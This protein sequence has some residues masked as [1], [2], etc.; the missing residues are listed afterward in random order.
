MSTFLQ[1]EIYDVGGTKRDVSNQFVRTD[2][3]DL[4]NQ[5]RLSVPGNLVELQGGDADYVNATPGVHGFPE[6]NGEWSHINAMG[7]GVVC[8]RQLVVSDSSI[9]EGVHFRGDSNP[10][11][12]VK[13]KTT[14][15][16]NTVIFRSCMFERTGQPKSPVW[17]EVES[18]AL[19]VFTGCV[20][21][22]GKYPN[23]GG[24]IISNAGAAAKVQLAGCISTTGLTYATVTSSGQGNINT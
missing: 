23:T 21:R 16:D 20:F 11:V 5:L 1:K 15:V 7:G 13:A 9:V 24:V 4:I 17:V 6:L 10:L 8:D 19:V 14:P 22:G 3:I 12:L 2:T 18:G